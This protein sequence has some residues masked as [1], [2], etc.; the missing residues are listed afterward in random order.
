MAIRIYVLALAAAA[1][2][3]TASCKSDKQQPTGPQP[4]DFERIKTNK[5]SLEARHLI[6]QFFKYTAEGDY[7]SAAAMLYTVDVNNPNEDPQPLDNGEIERQMAMLKAV[8]MIDA[9]IEYMKFEDFYSNEVMCTVTMAKGLDGAPD[10]TTK[11][12]FKPVNCLGTWYLCMMNSATGDNT[13]VNGD[14]RDSMGLEYKTEVRQRE[15]ARP[16][17][18]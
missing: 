7:A 8:P 3:L 6:E 18:R 4:T 9:K 10:V 14:K 17:Q 5:D 16:K 2:L 1:L 13:I 15:Q 11:M 12:F